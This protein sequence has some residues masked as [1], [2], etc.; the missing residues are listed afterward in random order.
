MAEN[1]MKT[2]F[3]SARDKVLSHKTTLEEFLRVVPREQ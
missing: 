3:D 2:L 1:K